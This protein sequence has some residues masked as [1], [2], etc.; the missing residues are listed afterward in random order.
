MP[1]AIYERDCAEGTV[2]KG[3]A[4]KLGIGAPKGV[5]DMKEFASSAK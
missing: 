2:P 5:S 1:N 3:I 4:P